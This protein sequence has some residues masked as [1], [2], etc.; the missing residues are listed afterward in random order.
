GCRRSVSARHPPQNRVQGEASSRRAPEI[1]T[2]TST[3]YKTVVHPQSDRRWCE[4]RSP[5]SGRRARARH[6]HC[7][8]GHLPPVC[9]V[10]DTSA[11]ARFSDSISYHITSHWGQRETFLYST[12]RLRRSNL[13]SALRHLTAT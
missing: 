10:D 9:C 6:Y 13:L 12:P 11:L 8:Y 1:E 5:V 4:S 2:L 7:C 3:V